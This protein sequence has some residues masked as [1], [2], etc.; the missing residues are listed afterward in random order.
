MTTPIDDLD[1]FYA[2]A[3]P[4]DEISYGN[5]VTRDPRDFR[6]DPQMCT[7]KEVG[8]WQE[9]VAL[10]SAGGTP[11]EGNTSRTIRDD[12]GNLVAHITGTRWGIGTSIIRGGKP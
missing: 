11:D 4:Y 7:P 1:A 9:A 2:Q 12:N 5:P 8:A 6:P 3:G 10:I